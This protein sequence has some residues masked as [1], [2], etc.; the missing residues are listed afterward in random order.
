[1][2]YAVVVTIVVTVVISLLPI[3]M[4]AAEAF[5][6]QD[7]S[8]P[9]FHYSLYQKMVTYQDIDYAEIIL[10]PDNLSSFYEGTSYRIAHFLTNPNYLESTETFS[11]TTAIQLISHSNFSTTNDM[12][13]C[14]IIQYIASTNGEE[15]IKKR[16][17]SRRLYAMSDQDVPLC[18]VYWQSSSTLYS[19][20]VSPKELWDLYQ[21]WFQYAVSNWA[22]R[23]LKLIV[24]TLL[25][26]NIVSEGSDCNENNTY[27][28]STAPWDFSDPSA[29][30]IFL[31]NQ[32]EPDGIILNPYS[33]GGGELTIMGPWFS[34]LQDMVNTFLNE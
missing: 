17:G 5:Q 29:N 18:K 4:G 19:G 20:V 6:N 12:P 14:V 25:G 8:S 31:C 2:F 11:N 33:S 30:I 28:Y 26:E 15:I 27:Q 7:Q 34:G 22:L 23:R 24:Y 1:M 9:G 13:N 3:L 21:N 32:D 16:P 10:T